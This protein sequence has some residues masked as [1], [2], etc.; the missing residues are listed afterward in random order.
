MQRRDE[1]SLSGRSGLIGRVD[2]CGTRL[3]GRSSLDIRNGDYLACPQ[4]KAG[5][6]RSEG[7][8]MLLVT[9]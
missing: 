2:D 6:A 1:V 4:R 3:L 8:A 9:T 7:G 5:V